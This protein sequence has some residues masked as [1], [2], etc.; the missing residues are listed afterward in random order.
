M[1]IFSIDTAHSDNFVEKMNFFL[2]VIG[3]LLVLVEHNN[4]V[5]AATAK[6]EETDSS[7]ALTS[8]TFDEL[9]KNKTVF[10]KFYASYCGHCQE[11]APA[12]EK[13]AQEYVNHSQG[14]VASVDCVAEQKFCQEHFQI[15]GLP[16]LL[17]GDPSEMG[18]FLHEYRP[19]DKS[20]ETLS[21][22]A[23][24]II[25]TP[26]CSPANLDPC[27][28]EMRKQIESVLKLSE[29]K[30]AAEIKRKEDA[31]KK[32]DETFAKEFAKMQKK[33]DKLAGDHQAKMARIKQNIKMVKSVQ[34]TKQDEV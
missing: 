11:L 4:A 12:W 25:T 7:V 6:Q 14:L 9:T 1:N 17:Y 31:I 13:L 32:A 26:M 15:Q 27:E 30:L 8:S 28:P 34:E 10:I 18:A 5:D 2:L 33:Y 23:Q 21:E 19:L 22:F 24:D 16:T 20:Y 3:I 29:K